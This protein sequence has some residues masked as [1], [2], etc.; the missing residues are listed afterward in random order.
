MDEQQLIRGCIEGDRRA[1]KCLYDQ[2]SGR[3]MGVCLR[4]VKEQETARDVMQ[5]GFIKLFT[6]IDTYKGEGSFDGWVRRIFVNC[7]LQRLRERDVC[8]DACNIDDIY[9]AEIPDESTISAISTDELMSCIASL[10]DGYRKVFNLYAV[11]GYSH[12]EIGELLHISENTSRS[13]YMNA[14][15][16]LK[17]MLLEDGDERG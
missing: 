11:E 7:A 16:K 2:Y 4:Y 12:K 14:R 10:P 3:M 13:Q 17:K 8:E 9:Y 15:N 1:Q 6:H 5:D